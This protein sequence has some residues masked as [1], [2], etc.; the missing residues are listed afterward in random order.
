MMNSFSDRMDEFVIEQ[1]FVIVWGMIIIPQ[2][3]LLKV[4]KVCDGWLGR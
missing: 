1:Q 2:F 4:F 3:T